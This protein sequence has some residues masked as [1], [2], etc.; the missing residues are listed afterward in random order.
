LVVFPLLS[1]QTTLWVWVPPPQ[2]AEQAPNPPADQLYVKHACGLQV[3]AVE[4][5][6]VVQ[7]LSATVLP[8]ESWQITD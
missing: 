2:V 4:G 6:E 7:K 8:L 3:C 5:F 1:L